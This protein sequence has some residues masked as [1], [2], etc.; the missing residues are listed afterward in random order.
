MKNF[1]SHDLKRI[2]SQQKSLALHISACEIVMKR[3]SGIL[4]E[5]LELQED[6]M[7]GTKMKEY[8]AFL[9]DSIARQFN[10]ATI[11]RLCCLH[12]IMDDGLPEKEYHFLQRRLLQA[13]GYRHLATLHYLQ[14]LGLFNQRDSKMISLEPLLPDRLARVA[15][16][17]SFR[18]ERM[19][20]RKICQRLNLLPL[21]ES[22][23]PNPCAKSGQHSSYVFRGVYTPLVYHFVERCL[24]EK[25][26]SFGDY[27]RCFG[28]N[29][30]IGDCSHPQWGALRK[31]LVCFIGGVTSAEV[32]SL[33]I[34]SRQFGRK[35]VSNSLGVLEKAKTQ[36]SSV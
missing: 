31:I 7:S 15:H 29:L 11:L 30:Q 22:S 26:P 1:V 27:V 35:I 8:L 36:T 10:L 20:F 28:N 21:D 9:E 3:Q 23:Q 19:R 25:E 17:A 4:E 6:A 14:R 24:K 12:S 16:A 18:S 13:Y 34:L 2:Q 5:L 33:D 32:A